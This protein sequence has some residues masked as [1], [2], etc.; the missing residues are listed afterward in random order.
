MTASRTTLSLAL[1]L[2]ITACE[3]SNQELY[4]EVM[5]IHDEV[6]PKM[7]DLYKAKTALTKRLKENPDLNESDKKEIHAKI[8]QIDSASEGMMVWM[9]Q[10]DPLPDSLGEDKAKA[11]LQS[12]LV[13]VKKVR[14]DI[15]QALESAY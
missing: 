3:Q 15:L 9:R 4:D 8:A 6:M 13:K 1:L 2:I 5:E 14:E 7:D 12:E 10:F 11:Y